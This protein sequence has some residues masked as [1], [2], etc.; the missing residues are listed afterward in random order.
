MPAL[1]RLCMQGKGEIDLSQVPLLSSQHCLWATS[2]LAAKVGGFLANA[3]LSS[4]VDALNKDDYPLV[5]QHAKFK[6]K[7]YALDE[8]VLDVPA[9]VHELAK[10]HLDLIFKID[11]M[12][13]DDLHLDA[14]GK[15]AYVTLRAGE[16]EMQLSAEHFVFTAGEGNEV[17]VEK[18]NQPALAMQRRPLHMV[19]AKTPFDYALYA[20]CVGMGARPRITITTHHMKDGS[21]VWYLGGLLAETGVERNAEQQIQ[22][23]REELASLFPWLDFSEVEFATFRIDR[24]E[25]KQKSG[26]KP[27]T[28]FC[29]TYGN[30][31]IGWPTKL[32]LAP[33][34][35][36]EIMTQMNVNK[37][38]ALSDSLTSWPH[39]SIAEPIWEQLFCK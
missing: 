37:N 31:T 28:S 26:L 39:A 36:A 22:A 29:S 35:A 16:R 24:A 27:E 13:K 23:A 6:G 3:T 38:P 34:L 7:V 1:W 20:H 33:K 32:A 2:K 25:P 18:L 5:F 21:A 4:R 10:P 17:V 8:I 14:N 11:A 15:L 12:S 30:I 19:L 9:L